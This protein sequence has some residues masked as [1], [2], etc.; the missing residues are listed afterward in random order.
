MSHSSTGTTAFEAVYGIYP[1]T[2]LSY[3]LGTSWVEGVDGFLHKRDEILHSL[4]SHLLQAHDHMKLVVDCHRRYMVC[5][6][7]DLVYLKLQPY[8]Q[9][10]V[11]LRASLKLSLQFY[12]PYKILESIGSVAYQLELPSGARLHD[13]FMLVICEHILGTARSFNILTTIH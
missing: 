10:L 13:F 12:G 5:D 11:E 1:P 3:V 8:R 4:H 6:V 7:G 9:T 2:I